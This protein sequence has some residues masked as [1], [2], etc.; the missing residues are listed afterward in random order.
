[1]SRPLISFLLPTR[2]RAALATRAIEQ[3]AA[4]AADPACFEIL[5]GVDD[6]DQ[7]SGAAIRA[8]CHDL[9]P[10]LV[11]R[12]FPPMGYAN[13]HRYNNALAQAATGRWLAIWNDDVVMETV[14]WD[15]EL[16]AIDF[17]CVVD[18]QIRNSNQT[19]FNSGLFPIVP[20]S[21]FDALGHLSANPHCDTYMFF[22]AETLKIR[23]PL[24]TVYHD[25]FDESGRNNDAT[26]QAR[27]Y[28][29][30]DFYNDPDVIARV[31]WD[32]RRLGRLIGRPPGVV[33]RTNLRD[34]PNPRVR[35][36]A[37]HVA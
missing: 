26:Y 27:E 33:M 5:L 14:K 37:S 25:R 2:L 8:A 34:N 6:D 9:G 15:N 30:I 4:T 1:M 3:L 11:L 18:P 24:W 31:N 22:V 7:E 32:A 13:L 10:T 19:R 23:H 35:R 36:H 12:I 29:T 16:R 20:R 21:W 17:F 28:K